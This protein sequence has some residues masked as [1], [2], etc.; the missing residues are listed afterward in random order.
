MACAVETPRYHDSTLTRSVLACSVRG[1]G[2]P[3]DRDAHAFVCSRGHSYDVAR[4]G[5]VNLLQPQDRRSRAAGDSA[6][7]LDARAR[8]LEAGVGR[9]LLD[10]VVERASRLDFREGAPV[11]DLGFG[12]GD[13]LGELARRRTITAIGIDLSTAAATVAA[14]RFPSMTWVVANAD[15][16]LPLVDGGVEL[17]LSIN[18][19]RNPAECARVLSRAGYLLAAIPAADDLVELREIVQ[20]VR[21]ERGRADALIREHAGDFTLLEQTT[22]REGRSLERSQLI[23][24]LRGTYRGNRSSLA[25]RVEALTTL[26]VTLASELL[27]FAPR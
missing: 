4:S 26:H 11:V 9:A 21:V 10:A 25:A 16:T 23:D 27:L 5:Y 1:C 22:V 6:D 8:L 19:R 18:A 12:G 13:A 14:R 15:R 2:L 7:A 20:G 24:L 17:A 3:L